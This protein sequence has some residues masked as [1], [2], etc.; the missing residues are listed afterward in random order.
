MGE[1][2]WGRPMMVYEAV[3]DDVSLHAHGAG[4]LD[5]LKAMLDGPGKAIVGSEGLAAALQGMPEDRV[6]VGYLSLQGLAGFAVGAARKAMM[7]QMPQF[8]FAE[9][10]AI[11]FAVSVLPGGALHGQLR[12]PVAA[13]RSTV[14]G[15]RTPAQPAEPFLMQP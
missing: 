10:P 14:D 6:A 8:S 13:V 11:G 4:S 15:F 12:V 3:K 9:A 2:L 7:P 5:A 1:A